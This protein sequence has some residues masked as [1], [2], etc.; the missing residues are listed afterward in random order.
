M[1]VLK[2]RLVAAMRVMVDQERELDLRAS[3]YRKLL[4]EK[5]ELEQDYASLEEEYGELKRSLPKR[6][7]RGRFSAH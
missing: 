3:A 2:S 5:R 7:A 4:H 6:D 1:F